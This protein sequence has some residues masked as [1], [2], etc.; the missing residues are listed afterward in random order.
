MSDIS[1]GVAISWAS[2]SGRRVR[3]M[4]ETS[5]SGASAHP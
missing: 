2:G 4:S 3:S 5:S 1:G